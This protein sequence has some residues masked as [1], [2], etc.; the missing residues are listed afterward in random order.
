MVMTAPMKPLLF[1]GGLALLTL[2]TPAHAQTVTKIL[3]NGPDAEKKVMVIIGDGF[4]AAGM[5]AYHQYVQDEIINGVFARD[6]YFRANHSAFNIYRVDVSS[7]ESGV[8][9]RRYEAEGCGTSEVNDDVVDTSCNETSSPACYTHDT[10]FDFVYTG[11]WGRCW[12]EGSANTETAIKTLLD[13]LVPKR[14]LEVRVLNL[15]T[16]K[17]G[18]CGGG[19]KFTVTTGTDWT[20]VAHEMGHMVS[21]LYDEYVA[22]AYETTTYPH[23]AVNTKN[24]STVLSRTSVV[25]S[26]YLFPN[27]PL[28][29]V[30]DPFTMDEDETVGEFEG[31]KT[32]GRGIYRPVHNCRMNGNV[33][34]FCPVCQNLLKQT[35][36]GFPDSTADYAFYAN[37]PG[38]ACKAAGTAAVSYNTAANVSNPAAALATVLC[39]TRRV[40]DN[41]VFTNHLMGQAFVVDQHPTENVCCQLFARTPGGEVSTGA[42][43]CSTGSSSSM[44]SLKLDFPKVRMDYTFAHFALKCSLPAASSGVASSVL[45]YRIGQQSY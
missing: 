13:Q 19:G 35:L 1:L 9:I 6:E 25:W 17:M 36:A 27:I 41:G 23:D 10:A 14:D 21:N 39:P 11:C 44:Q 38:A 18:G 16:G 7:P 43:V 30:F 3:D 34:E 20:V 22:K 40:Q 15:L 45:T 4:T 31:C 8:S 33:N 24:C 26:D 12:M 32:Y 2:A 29:T 28:K 42:N 37:Y 5:N